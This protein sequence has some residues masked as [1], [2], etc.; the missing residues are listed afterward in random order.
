[1]P[2]IIE[3]P[4]EQN[5][6]NQVEDF[7]ESEEQPKQY[8][9]SYRQEKLER[10]PQH[11]QEVT[12]KTIPDVPMAEVFADVAEMNLDDRPTVA[13]IQEGSKSQRR[14]RSVSLG[15]SELILPPFTKGKIA[16]YRAVYRDQIDPATNLRPDL[17]DVLLPGTYQFY[18]KFEADPLRRSKLM[19]NLGREEVFYNN[20]TRT[21][22][23]RHD[24]R[25][26]EL[27]N[28]MLDVN[29]EKDYR[30]YVFM[31]LH[32]L[33]ASNKHRDFNNTAVFERIDLKTEFTTAYKSAEADLAR[34]AEDAVIHKITSADR[35]IGMAVGFD[36]PVHG[37]VPSDIKHDL[38]LKARE[39][40]KKF[41]SMSNSI[42]PAI[43]LNIHDG[44]GKGIIQFNVDR[45]RFEFTET[46]K[47]MHTVPIGEDGVEDFTKTILRDK[48]ARAMYDEMMDMLN[49]WV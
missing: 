46:G 13:V 40:P 2:P 36:I 48:D 32:P 10:T 28:G 11:L 45:N 44:L 9:K 41:F 31:E 3:R 12:E 29:I 47:V 6:S 23:K 43:K 26:I 1:M 18:D 25:E 38:R 33:N 30:L 16:K 20:V 22:E 19:K 4:E 8:K 21:E 34:D 42:K 7:V 5:K 39:D 37:R 15:L 14:R 35:I 27:L 49:Y 24:I 17:T